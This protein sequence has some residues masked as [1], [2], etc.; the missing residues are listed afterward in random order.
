MFE[1]VA[2]NYGNGGCTRSVHCLNSQYILILLAII[3]MKESG[4]ECSMTVH[5]VV[6]H[7]LWINYVA[8]PTSYSYQLSILKFY[9]Y[10]AG[11]KKDNH[12]QQQLQEAQWHSCI[13]LK[14]GTRRSMLGTRLCCICEHPQLHHIRVLNS[15]RLQVSF[16]IKQIK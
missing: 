16:T 4:L 3:G 15:G 12:I 6:V 9:S 2:N 10:V 14:T 7:V 13:G 8:E 11:N 1:L 5:T